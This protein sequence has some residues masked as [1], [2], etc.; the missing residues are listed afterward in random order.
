M[1]RKKIEQQKNGCF[2]LLE[3]RNEVIIYSMPIIRTGRKR[4]IIGDSLDF[5]N[6]QI[7]L[8][9]VVLDPITILYVD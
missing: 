5:K 1:I 2:T 6:A 3:I 4:K 9:K 8:Q 7:H